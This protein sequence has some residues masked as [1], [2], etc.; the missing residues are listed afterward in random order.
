LC[1]TRPDLNYAVGQVAKYSSNPDQSHINAVKRI[2]A[3]V[4]G[5]ADYGICFGSKKD[6]CLIAFCD[7]DY[8]GD[9]DTRRSTTGY[10]VMLNGGPVTWGSRQ[11]Q[12]VSLSTTEAKY[13]AAC[14]TTRQISWFRNLLQDV[15]I[16]QKAPTPLFCDNQGAI[17]LSKNPEKHKRTK[18]I[19]VQ[20]HYVRKAKQRG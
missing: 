12:C 19:D 14:E 2:F 17:H 18:H 13:V 20:Y 10:V 8:A 11:Q 6:D 3:Y 7:A 15:G 1:V 9:I 4:K 16:V 5:T